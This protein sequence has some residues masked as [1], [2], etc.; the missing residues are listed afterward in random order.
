MMKLLYDA[1]SIASRVADMADALNRDLG[2]HKLVHVVVTMNGGFVFAAD[3][4]RQLKMPLVLHFTGGS[5]FKGNI[6]QDVAMNPETLPTAFHGA[7]VLIV[8][9]I[10]D[11]GNAVRQL[12]QALAERGA[13]TQTVVTLFK[14]VGS[15]S[16]ATH[17]AFSLPK[18]LFVVGYGLDMDGRYRELR[19]IFTFEHS[20]MTG[21]GG[22]C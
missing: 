4:C 17:A 7:P 11:S 5:Y 15:P 20:V 22:V 2:H 21:V 18:E 6:K 1:G 9:D 12:K 16:E 14:R 13:G 8:E 3:L 19:D 10:L